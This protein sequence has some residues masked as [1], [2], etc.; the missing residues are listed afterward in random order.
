MKRMKIKKGDTVVVI[1]GKDKGKKGKVLKVCPAEMKLIVE[2]VNIAKRHQKPTRTFQGGIIEK[3]IPL[4]VSKVML[5]CPR[6]NQPSRIGS[7]K[8]SD[9]S[10]RVCNRCEE[11]VDK[12]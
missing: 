5:V 4:A 6:C 1:S 9:R 7:K 2:R 3:P 10:V 11:I 12:E 8:I